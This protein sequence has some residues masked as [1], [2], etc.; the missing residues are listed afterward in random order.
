MKRLKVTRRITDHS[1]RSRVWLDRLANSRH[2]FRAGNQD[3]LWSSIRSS[4]LG[5][6][7]WLKR[8]IYRSITYNILKRETT[9]GTVRWRRKRALMRAGPRGDVVWK[10]EG[11][12]RHFFRERLEGLLHSSSSHIYTVKFREITRSTGFFWLSVLTR[13]L[14]LALLNS[15]QRE[16]ECDSSFVRLCFCGCCWR[17]IHRPDPGGAATLASDNQKASNGV[18][19][20]A[21]M[22]TVSKSAEIPKN[23][24]QA[25][26]TQVRDSTNVVPTL[27][28]MANEASEIDSMKTIG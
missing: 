25:K 16:W 27:N 1:C 2:Q 18:K 10:G 20:P 19:H 5:H 26:F 8:I 6:F 9:D 21:T 24:S 17:S 12:V 13:A 14:P 28:G 22:D 15:N 4:K 23:T 3:K 7:K 11:S